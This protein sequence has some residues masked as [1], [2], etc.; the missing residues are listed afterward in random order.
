[1]IGIN[2]Q[3]MDKIRLEYFKSKSEC[4]ASSIENTNDEDAAEMDKAEREE[5]ELKKEIQKVA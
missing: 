4:S 1:M 3:V 5:L 2:L